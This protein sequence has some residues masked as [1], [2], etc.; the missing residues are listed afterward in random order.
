MLTT[1]LLDLKG[2]FCSTKCPF[3]KYVGS[4]VPNFRCLLLNKVINRRRA[5]C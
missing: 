3:R 2:K 5:V 1:N 4:P